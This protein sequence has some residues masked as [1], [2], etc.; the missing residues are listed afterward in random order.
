MELLEF[1]VSSWD[2]TIEAFKIGE[3]VVPILVED[4]Y[5]LTRLSRRG[6][7]ISLLGSALRGETVRDYILQYC[8]PGDQP[9]KDGKMNIR[10]VRDLPLRTILYMMLVPLHYT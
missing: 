7:P 5:F 8:N 9:S 4:I 6:L 10:N 2:P 1:L 3:N